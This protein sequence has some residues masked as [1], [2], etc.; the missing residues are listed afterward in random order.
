[1]IKIV[2]ANALYHCIN[3]L[4]QPEQ[5]KLADPIHSFPGL[6]LDPSTSNY[7]F[8]YLTSTPLRN[9]IIVLWHDLLNNTITSHP[10]KAT[11]PK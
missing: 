1:M 10:K 7:C 3:K 8:N 11:Y 6:N 2:G 4:D 5:G 9:C